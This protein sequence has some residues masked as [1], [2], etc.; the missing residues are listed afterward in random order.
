MRPFHSLAAGGAD[1]DAARPCP[2]GGRLGAA[3]APDAGISSEQLP[4]TFLKFLSGS[5]CLQQPLPA[6]VLRVKV[7]QEERLGITFRAAQA[8]RPS[9]CVTAG[10]ARLV[11][12]EVTGSWR[13]GGRVQGLTRHEAHPAAARF[14]H[15]QRGAQGAAGTRGCWGG[16]RSRAPSQPGR[17]GPCSW[18]D[19]AF[20]GLQPPPASPEPAA[21]GPCPGSQCCGWGCSARAFPSQ[22]ALRPHFL[23]PGRLC[24]RL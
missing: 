20:A 22:W 24:Q 6:P 17:A 1:R 5:S 4:P 11:C 16:R 3:S 2:P 9:S 7:Q 18:E 10:T 12:S 8:C 15:T 19:L 14:P 21:P 13:T 23:L